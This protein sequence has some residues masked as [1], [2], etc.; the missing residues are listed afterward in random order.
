MTDSLPVNTTTNMLAG[1][2]AFVSLHE[3]SWKKTQVTREKL[4]FFT[5]NLEVESPA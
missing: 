5:A 1:H 4:I 2:T 3:A